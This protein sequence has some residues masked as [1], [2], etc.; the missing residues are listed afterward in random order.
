[1][2]G[3]GSRAPCPG[4]LCKGGRRLPC[5]AGPGPCAAPALGPARLSGVTAGLGSHEGKEQEPFV[6]LLEQSSSAGVGQGVGFTPGG[7]RLLKTGRAW[8]RWGLCSLTQHLLQDQSR[9]SP[10]WEM[11]PTTQQTP[12][13]CVP[14]PG[15][16][17]AQSLLHCPVSVQPRPGIG[18]WAQLPL[19]LHRPPHS[20]HPGC[21]QVPLGHQKDLAETFEAALRVQAAACSCCLWHWDLALVLPALG[22]HQLGLD[23]WS[24]LPGAA[25]GLLVWSLLLPPERRRK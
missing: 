7:T 20:A 24:P 22:H 9:L 12:T 25:Q 8:G 16:R 23:P 1:M 13:P 5:G 4:W 2:L 17:A 11:S 21:C 6:L 18:L 3:P 15:G 19:S 10:S 14:S